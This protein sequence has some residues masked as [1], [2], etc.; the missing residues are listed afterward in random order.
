MIWVPLMFLLGT[1]CAWAA[2]AGF[3]NS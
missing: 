1:V 3:T 2:I